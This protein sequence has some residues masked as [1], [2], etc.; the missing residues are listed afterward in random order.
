MKQCTTADTIEYSFFSLGISIAKWEFY[1]ITHQTNLD[2]KSRKRPRDYHIRAATFPAL[3]LEA[4]KR[5]IN[6][7]I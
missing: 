5:E 2:I 7:C 3:A 4:A 6:Q 1:K